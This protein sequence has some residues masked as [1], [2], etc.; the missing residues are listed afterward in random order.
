MEKYGIFKVY[1]IIV[2]GYDERV[3]ENR[4]YYKELKDFVDLLSFIDYVIFLRFF[5]DV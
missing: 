3:I 2:G 5:F 1:F 4:E